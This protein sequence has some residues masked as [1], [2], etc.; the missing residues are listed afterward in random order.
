[1]FLK[2]TTYKPRSNSQSS[3]SGAP[4]DIA[5][6]NNSPSSP[7]NASGPAN[8][9]G[10]GKS[11]S[12]NAQV[13]ANRGG[14]GA[15]PTPANNVGGG[16]GWG[17]GGIFSGGSAGGRR[18]SS[19]SEGIFSGLNGYKRNSQDA[20]GETRRASFLEQKP[21]SGGLLSNAWNNFTKGTGS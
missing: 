11:S 3:E 4:K 19:A 13:S 5:G 21:G 9:L 16:A 15:T 17:D 14:T 18:R 1:M 7:D 20:A 10:K 12:H 6:G 2:Q 8:V